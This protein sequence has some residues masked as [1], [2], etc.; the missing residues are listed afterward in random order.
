MFVSASIKFQLAMKKPRPLVTCLAK[1]FKV[2]KYSAR[3]ESG[4]W[5]LCGFIWHC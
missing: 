5:K 3:F 1:P 4:Y 2:W